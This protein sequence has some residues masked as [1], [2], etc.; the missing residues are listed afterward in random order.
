VI[1]DLYTRWI[2]FSGYALEFDALELGERPPEYEAMDAAMLQASAEVLRP[3]FAELV[4]AGRD[5]DASFFTLSKRKGLPH[6]SGSRRLRLS[7]F[8]TTTS[9]CGRGSRYPVI[10]ESYRGSEHALP[11]PKNCMVAARANVGFHKY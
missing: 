10:S 5:G 9:Y 11:D 6:L 3:F 2:W 7:R 1:H 4:Q 8:R